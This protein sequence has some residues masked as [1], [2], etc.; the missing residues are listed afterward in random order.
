MGLLWGGRGGVIAFIYRNP[1]GSR[2]V[3][4]H[5]SP[6][7][8]FPTGTLRAMVAA[9]GWS[10]EDLKRLGLDRQLVAASIVSQAGL[11][12]ERGRNPQ[13]DGRAERRGP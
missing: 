5:H 9:A 2:V 13:P 4:A 7:Q 6:G 3:A 12:L 1:D 10:D 11:K 8:L